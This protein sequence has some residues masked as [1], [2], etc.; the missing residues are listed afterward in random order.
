VKLK[1]ICQTCGATATLDT[2]EPIGPEPRWENFELGRF[3]IEELDVFEDYE[4]WICP[5][6][7]LSVIENWNEEGDETG[8][9]YWIAEIDWYK[10]RDLIKKSLHLKEK[11]KNEIAEMYAELTEEQKQYKLFHQ[12]DSNIAK[13]IRTH[14]PK[15][16]D[17]DEPQRR[18]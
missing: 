3:E 8:H 17:C 2:E 18:V 5:R 10:L 1:V 12:P 6:C 4:I 7:Y 9:R 16:R 11:E 15:F 13:Y 14:D